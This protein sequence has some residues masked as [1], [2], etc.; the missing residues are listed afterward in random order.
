MSGYGTGRGAEATN[1]QQPD[2]Y[3]QAALMK[4]ESKNLDIA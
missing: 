4:L 3:F 2:D 1:Y